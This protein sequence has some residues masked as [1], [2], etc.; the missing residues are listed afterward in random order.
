MDFQI[1][2]SRPESEGEIPGYYSRRLLAKQE[3]PSSK[4]MDRTR[5][6]VMTI[7]TG[8][9]DSKIQ[10]GEDIDAPRSLDFYSN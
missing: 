7:R 1:P 9:R 4:A 2:C 8:T 3:G 6:S 5:T 10:D